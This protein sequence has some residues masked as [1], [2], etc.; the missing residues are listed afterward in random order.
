MT[1]LSPTT[2]VL[3]QRWA[4]D[5]LGPVWALPAREPHVLGVC[6]ESPAGVQCVHPMK[7]HLLPVSSGGLSSLRRHCAVPA[8]QGRVLDVVGA[9]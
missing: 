1:I 4:S 7:K 3:N 9:Q 8:A 5:P 2:A 6:F